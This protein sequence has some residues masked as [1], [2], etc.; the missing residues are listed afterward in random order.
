[1]TAERSIPYDANG[2]FDMTFDI[3]NEIKQRLIDNNTEGDS[4][5]QRFERDVL[6]LLPPAD[7]KKVTDALVFALDIDYHHPGLS[8]Q[9]YIKHPLRVAGSVVTL[10]QL[11]DPDIIITALV[12]NV[13]EVSDVSASRLASLFG[14][15]VAS[16]V[17]R[18][19]V[20]RARD[21]L[22]YKKKYYADIAGGWR[23]ARVVKVLDK[24]DNIFMIGFNPDESIRTQYL[25]EIE[26][27]VMP[28]AARDVPAVVD[29]IARVLNFMRASG[30]LQK[31]SF[32]G[33]PLG[34]NR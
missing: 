12:H 21:N 10:G 20:D 7:R 19:T 6:S 34:E 13:L 16:A 28:M 29:H 8:A 2:S 24:Y 26:T 15:D 33:G 9:T 11:R 25:N 5:L 23:G 27:H 3:N 4:S 32:T 17:E 18:L 31:A 14:A 22:A 30:Y 1:M